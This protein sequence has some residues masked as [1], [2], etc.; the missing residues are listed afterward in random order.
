[1]GFVHNAAGLFA[2]RFF[3]GMFEVCLNYIDI[4]DLYL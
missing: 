2:A 4:N 3:L 1:M